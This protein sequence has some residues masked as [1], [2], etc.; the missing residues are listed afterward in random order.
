[1]MKKEINWYHVNFNQPTGADRSLYMVSDGNHVGI[2]ILENLE[3]REEWGMW[4]TICLD[5]DDMHMMQATH[6][7]FEV[8]WYLDFVYWAE[9]EIERF[10]VDT[11][12]PAKFK[13]EHAEDILRCKMRIIEQFGTDALRDEP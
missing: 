3:T 12:D 7:E 10:G 13:L 6:G 8:S 2:G 1:M 5:S 11:S 4:D 9:L